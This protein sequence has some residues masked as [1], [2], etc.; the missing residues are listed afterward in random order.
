MPMNVIQPSIEVREDQAVV[1]TVLADVGEAVLTLGMVNSLAFTVSNAGTAALTDFALLASTG[2]SAPFKVLL[3]GTD[4]DTASGIL[5]VTDAAINTL[6]SGASA[7][8]MAKVGPV[9]AVKFQ[10]KVGSGSA[11]LA[12]HGIV[13]NGSL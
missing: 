1:A 4:W 8:A 11:A 2:P 13:N 7:L 3:S 10:A 12:V 5:T 9:Y 6:A